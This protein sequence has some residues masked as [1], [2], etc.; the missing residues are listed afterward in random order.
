MELPESLEKMKH[1]AELI[2]QLDA[3]MLIIHQNS[4]DSERDTVD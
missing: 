2:F 1:R 4:K 3:D